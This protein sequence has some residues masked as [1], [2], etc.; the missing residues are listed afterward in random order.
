MKAAPYFSNYE[1]KEKM[2]L[3]E[4][5]MSFSSWGSKQKEV[6]YCHVY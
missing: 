5:N 2:L 4:F 3:T 6:K 1:I